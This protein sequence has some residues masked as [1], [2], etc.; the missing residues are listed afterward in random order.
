MPSLSTQQSIDY[1]KAAKTAQDE[2]GDITPLALGKLTRDSPIIAAS[3]LRAM[4]RERLVEARDEDR[5]TLTPKG[6][7]AA[8]GDV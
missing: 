3:F 5:W 7:R 2:H 1:C 4:E 8:D 6:E